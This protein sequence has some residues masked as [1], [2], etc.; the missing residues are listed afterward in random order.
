LLEPLENIFTIADHSKCLAFMLG[1]GIVPSNVKAGYLARLVLRRSIRLIDELELDYSLVDLVDFQYDMLKRD[2]PELTE[3]KDT[4][5]EILDLE[6]KR[7]RETLSK[8]K[9]LIRSFAKGLK[10]TKEIPLEQLMEFYDSKGIHPNIVEKV[11]RADG[12]EVTIPDNFHALISERHSSER[13]ESAAEERIYDLPD[14]RRLYYEDVNLREFEG[15]VIS[16]EPPHVILDSTI[17]YPEGGGQP[18]DIGTL[19]APELDAEWDVTDV[20][21][22]GGV[23]VHKLETGGE[24]GKAPQL[25]KKGMKVSG[26]LNWPRRLSLMQHHSSTHII[27]GSARKV[28]GNQVWQTGAQKF[29]DRARVDITHFA[30]ITPEQLR[31]I[32]I[33]ANRTVLEARKITAEWLDRSE[34]EKRYGF[35][36]YQGGVP[37]GKSIRVVEIAGFDVEACGGTHCEVTTQVGA[38]KILRNERIQDGVER[39]EFATGLSAIRN[40]QKQEKILTDS[41]EILSV[42]TEQLPRTVQRFFTEWKS[43]RKEL[44]E[45]RERGAADNID[46]LAGRSELVEG[47][48]VRLIYHLEADGEEIDRSRF[49]ALSA[50]GRELSDYKFGK[51]DEK[52]AAV[53][54]ANFGGGKLILACNKDL[55]INCSTLIKEA[56][57][58]IG[59]KG[60]GRPDFAVGGGPDASKIKEAMK[61]AKEDLGKAL[62]GA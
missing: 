49:E 1:D 55:E 48:N 39:L 10:D 56:S 11:A 13:P 54:G 35:R 6:T 44:A 26:T 30:K 43:Q 37:P 22:S 19:R 59:G 4:V 53:L 32:E 62:T 60:G 47:T 50:L 23:I 27:L 9:K 18:S 33:T 57:R 61:K 3:M 12:F 46:I 41:S 51:G 28:L 21:K 8:G 40:I 17:F 14:T 38:I 20:Q 45:L 24:G 25:L 2:F 16:V 5:F 52:I 31:E 36:L 7:Y 42:P 58:L 34:A 29:P 15:E